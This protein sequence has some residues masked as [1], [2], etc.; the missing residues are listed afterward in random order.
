[1]R[2]KSFPNKVADEVLNFSFGNLD[3]ILES[4]LELSWA[5][6][7]KS[8][9]F[10]FFALVSLSLCS[11][12]LDRFALN[13]QHHF[14][15]FSWRRAS[16]PSWLMVMISED[17]KAIKRPLGIPIGS[18]EVR[19]GFRRG[20]YCISFLVSQARLWRANHSNLGFENSDEFFCQESQRRFKY[21]LATVTNPYTSQST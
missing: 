1:M 6:V 13:Q 4:A 2:R 10:L 20:N 3:G 21:S 8:A 5:L 17:G 7:S 11:T 14:S 19:P 9:Q 15:G 16:M 18:V 12:E